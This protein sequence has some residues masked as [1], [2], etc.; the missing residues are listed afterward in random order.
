MR[1]PDNADCAAGFDRVTIISPIGDADPF[2]VEVSLS[3]AIPELRRL[4]ARVDL[5]PP[6]ETSR[7]AIGNR[8]L[9]ADSR[10]PAA[11]AGRTQGRALELGR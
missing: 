7:A 8:V 6:D 11:K 1:S 4:G 10:T 3:D 5:I 2:P 9:D